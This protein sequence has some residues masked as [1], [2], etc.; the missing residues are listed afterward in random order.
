MAS[1]RLLSQEDLI[2]RDTGVVD[3]FQLRD[4]LVGLLAL[5][6]THQLIKRPGEVVVALS[7]GPS[8]A[9]LNGLEQSSVTAAWL[10]SC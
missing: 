1:E 6:I 10:E 7:L 5:E 3:S 4:E 8:E 9:R 2:P